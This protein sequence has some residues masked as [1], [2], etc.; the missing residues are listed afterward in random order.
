MNEQ[1]S[2]IVAGLKTVREFHASAA[3][4][5]QLATAKM[6]E[7]GWTVPIRSA[8]CGSRG[9]KA[10]YNAAYWLPEDAFQF[11]R[12]ETQPLVLA[13]IALIFD[14][15]ED[16]SRV[17]EPIITTGK[18]TFAA[19]GKGANG[20]YHYPWCRTILS[21]EKAQRTSGQWTHQQP[22]EVVYGSYYQVESFELLGSDLIAIQ[23]ESSL[24]TAIVGPLLD[25]LASGCTNP[26][27]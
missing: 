10:L 11:Y 20:E 12:H 24:V 26:V 16:E 13:Y 17:T 9:S 8:A 6:N 22:S 14:D 19:E 21:A 18:I 27:T 1:G 15:A 23:Y 2:Q 3:K 4:L 25:R 7:Q 5:L